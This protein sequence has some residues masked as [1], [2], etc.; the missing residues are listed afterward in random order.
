MEK[1]Y[2]LYEF[3]MLL[4]LGLWQGGKL[5]DIGE[6]SPLEEESSITLPGLTGYSIT[7]SVMLER[8]GPSATGAGYDLWFSVTD[9]YSG[10]VRIHGFRTG[11]IEEE[12]LMDFI[13]DVEKRILFS[14]NLFKSNPM[15]IERK[16]VAS[17][18]SMWSG[19]VPTVKR[20]RF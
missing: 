10:A 11:S 3:L 18:Y 17:H 16:Y 7:P 15:R 20:R 5:R 2:S 6:V 19:R 1:E 9:P 12:A 8:F 4:S 14:H 13:T